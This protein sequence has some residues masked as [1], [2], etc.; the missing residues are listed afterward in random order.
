MNE[1]TPSDRRCV[2]MWL[3]E[4][5]ENFE[6]G[7]TGEVWGRAQGFEFKWMRSPRK[8]PQLFPACLHQSGR[9]P[10]FFCFFYISLTLDFQYAADCWKPTELQ[11]LNTNT[12]VTDLARECPRGGFC[13]STQT[14]TS[15][16]THLLSGDLFYLLQPFGRIST[17]W[18]HIRSPEQVPVETWPSSLSNWGTSVPWNSSSWVALSVT[19]A[20]VHA[21]VLI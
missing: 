16:W 2:T 21:N 19:A 15:Q 12:L 8:W 11:Q 1:A 9:W 10:F 13:A 18:G 4:I 6:E 3:P 20:P 17:T 14:E 5:K 7:H